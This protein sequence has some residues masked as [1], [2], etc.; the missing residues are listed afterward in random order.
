MEVT[1]NTIA[2][3]QRVGDELVNKSEYDVK[4]NLNQLVAGSIPAGLTLTMKFN[5]C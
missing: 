5:T 2:A 3:F 4:L 1:K